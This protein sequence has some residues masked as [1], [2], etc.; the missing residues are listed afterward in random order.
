MMGG[1]LM[2]VLRTGAQAAVARASWWLVRRFVL[3]RFIR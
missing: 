3:G 1:C 2:W